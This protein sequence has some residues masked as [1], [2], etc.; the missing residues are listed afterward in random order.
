M[1]RQIDENGNFITPEAENSAPDAAAGTGENITA[2][3]E[4]AQKSGGNLTRTGI[5][6]LDEKIQNGAVTFLDIENAAKAYGVDVK[7]LENFVKNIKGAGGGGDEGGDSE[8]LTAT[9]KS[10][11]TLTD[12]IDRTLQMGEVE[13]KNDVTDAVARWIYNKTGGITP[14]SAKNREFNDKNNEWIRSATQI[15]NPDARDGKSMI[16]YADERYG[17]FAQNDKEI[18][19]RTAIVAKTGMKQLSGL[20]NMLRNQGGQ[21]NDADRARLANLQQRYNALVSKYGGTLAK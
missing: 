16:D 11:N 4:R 2:P 13:G 5:P 21:L 14:L 9:R 20:L 7:R 6:E 1:L 15:V 12:S 19:Q 18:G 3:A 17:F 10:I 8:Q